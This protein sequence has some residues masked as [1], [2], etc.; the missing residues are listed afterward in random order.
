MKKSEIFRIILEVVCR[1]TEV[2]PD[3]VMSGCRQEDAVLAR[4]LVVGY[5]I[6]HGLTNKNLQE[7]LHLKSHAS[8]CYA[9]S[10]YTERM[11]TDRRFR[12]IENYTSREVV[13]A[14]SRSGQ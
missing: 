14:M 5:G 9:Q 8:I 6:K 1:C 3:L 11:R 2:T 7:F 10:Q 4:C 13:A 12:N